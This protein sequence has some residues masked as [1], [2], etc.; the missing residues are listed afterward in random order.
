MRYLLAIACVVSLAVPV[1]AFA[2]KSCCHGKKCAHTK[3]KC[4]HKNCK[5]DCKEK[6]AEEEKTS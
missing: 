6:K 1:A 4:D 3:A 2:G 5:G